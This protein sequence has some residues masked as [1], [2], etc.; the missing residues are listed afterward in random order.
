M[1]GVASDRDPHLFRAD[2]VTWRFL[3]HLLGEVSSLRKDVDWL[4]RKVKGGGREYQDHCT[5]LL[6]RVSLYILFY[7]VVK[8]G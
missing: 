3:M 2:S 6:N 8:Q 1:F 5:P 4:V 7:L